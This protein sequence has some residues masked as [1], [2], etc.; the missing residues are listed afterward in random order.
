[1]RKQKLLIITLIGLLSVAALCCGIEQSSAQTGYVPPPQLVPGVDYGLPNYSLSPIMR[2]FVDSLPLVGAGSP[3][4]LGNYI[5]TAVPDTTSYPGS[6]YYEM[7]I[8]DYTQ[9]MNSDL[10]GPC[11]TDT[12][13]A[14]TCGGATPGTELRGYVQIY[15]PGTGAGQGV[16]LTNPDGSLVMYNGAQVYAYD[17]PRYFGPII[18]ANQGTPTRIKFYNLLRTT[19]N[20]GDIFL[21]L[22]TTI[23]GTTGP[24]GAPYASNRA[25]IHLHGGDTPWISDGTPW[26]WFTPAGEN[27][28]YPTGASY[29]NVPDMPLPASGAVTL[30]YPNGQ[31]GRL[32]FIHDH[33]P[34]AT[35]Q[36]VYMGQAAGYLL[37]DPTEQ[38]LTTNFAPG[39]DIP[40]VIQTKGFVN[41]GDKALPPGYNDTLIAG[42]YNSKYSTTVMDPTWSNVGLDPEVAAWGQTTGSLWFPHVYMPNQN[43]NDPSGAN[44]MGRWDYGAWFWPVFPVT[45]NL[46][47]VSQVPESFFDTPIVNGQAYPY[48][49]VQPTTYRFRILD[50]TNERYLNLQWYVASSIVSAITLTGGGSGYT[51]PPPVTITPAAGDTTGLG[52]TATATVDLDPNSATYGQVTGI[53]LVSVG[54]GYTAPPVVTIAPPESGTQ[55]SAAATIYTGLTEV[56]MVPAS[57]TAPVSFPSWW[58]AN[59]TPGLTP[60]ILDN[61]PGGVP[62]PR[63]IGPSFIHIATE[64][65][66]APHAVELKDTPVGY[67]QNKRSV[68]VLNVLEHTLYLA[69]AE[70]AEV[71]VDFS[72]FAG[73]TLI[74]YNDAPAPLPA[75]DPRNDYYTGNPDNSF[76]GGGPPTQAGFGPNT[77]TIMQVRVANTPPSGSLN[78]VSLEAALNSAFTATQPAPI[79]TQSAYPQTSS[80]PDVYARISDTSLVTSGGPEPVDSVLIT[81]GGTGYQSVPT[82]QFVGGGGSGAAGFATV[83]NGAVT[84]VVLTS[85]GA[86]YTSNPAVQFIGGNPLTPAIAVANLVG[87]SP[88]EPKTIQELFDPLGRMNATLGVEVPFTSSAV[89]TTIPYGYGDPETEIIPNGG[90]QLWKITHNGVDT[91]LIHF[92]LFNVQLVNRVGWDGAIKPPSPEEIGWKETVKMNPLEDVIV[93]LKAKVPTLPASMGEL[94]DS[95]R[96]LEPGMPLGS[97]AY[98]FGV[99]PNNNPVS[100]VNQIVNFGHEYVWHCHL[101]GHEDNDMMRPM[102]V[103]V[104]PP[105]PTDLAVTT[106]G[107]RAVLSWTNNIAAPNKYMGMTVQRAS[108]SGFTTNLVTWNLGVVSTYTDTTFNKK[109]TPYYYRV[110]A[111]DTV[112]SGVAG[113]PSVTAAS[114]YTNVAGAPAGTSTLLTLT[115]AGAKSPVVI[116]WSYSA[117]DQTGFTI[118]RATNSTF[119]SGLTQFTVAG[120]VLTYSDNKTKSG[121]TYWYRVVA[122]NSLGDGTPSNSASITAQ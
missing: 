7:A 16:A 17:K 88:L 4:N 89:Q 65:G 111:T 75:G 97:T 112:G 103:A 44:P 47:L 87:S 100:V 27:T 52:A 43:P 42:G 33:V 110:F 49:V 38:A 101:L 39:G 50:I 122:T 41:K 61:R 104:P 13:G 11:S 1:M 109:G 55:A 51:A 54:S 91:H 37:H 120:N 113:Y 105:A 99:D 119:T 108:D 82:V 84:G 36:G 73:K 116:T 8:V 58:S 24:N 85:A 74:L 62:D 12:T 63:T 56:G 70:R 71:M 68:T 57:P 18:L 32:M 9:Q 90:T 92:H 64:G 46:P 79:V 40:L 31:S 30:Y 59:D 48:L 98:F 14:T 34:G 10:P 78:M 83:V 28:A 22:D 45:G 86:G 19:A 115:Q 118:Q 76:Q 69:P 95:I 121:V 96:P 72:K 102:S 93:A 81:T 106:Q 29:Q 6:D 20:G 60:D 35:R 53:T 2:K 15:P 3:S 26:Q 21:P 66:V 117:S 5:P 107:S 67:E 80:G 23:M 114:D 94:P 25:V 77:R